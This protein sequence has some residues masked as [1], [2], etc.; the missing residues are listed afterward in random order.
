[1]LVLVPR[2]RLPGALLALG[3]MSGAI[4]FHVVSPLGI[5]PYH[6]G[7]KLFKEACSVWLASAFIVFVQRRELMALLRMLR[8]R[9]KMLTA[10]M[11]T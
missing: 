3:I 11:S 7:G 9:S 10:R 1:L 8:E 2:T 6:D 5:D 4:F